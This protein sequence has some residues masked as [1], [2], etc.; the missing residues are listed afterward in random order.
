MPH[1]SSGRR[2]STLGPLE[3]ATILRASTAAV[4]DIVASASSVEM[5][6]LL[7]LRSQTT[8]RIDVADAPPTPPGLGSQSLHRA[9]SR[10]R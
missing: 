2:H 4:G 9:R 5:E 3:L 6:R 10:R 8:D 1:D 7:R